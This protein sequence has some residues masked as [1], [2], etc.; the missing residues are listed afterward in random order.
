M[1]ATTTSA[2]AAVVPA[3]GKFAGTTSQ[4]YSGIVVRFRVSGSEVENKTI[5]WH[6]RCSSGSVLILSTLTRH[7]RIVHGRWS[8]PARYTAS[9][10][11][12][13]LAKIKV[14]K[15]T[16]QFTSP[17]SAT[18]VWSLRADLYRRGRKFDACATGTVRWAAGS[19]ASGRKSRLIVPPDRRVG[20]L[21]YAQWEVRAWQWETA[22]LHV[23]SSPVPNVTPC[24]TAGQRGPVWFL[25]ADAYAE[26]FATRS[27]TVP[28]GR[29]L[30]I[31]VPS[32]DCSTVERS[33][34]HATTDGGLLRCSK[35]KRLGRASLAV[36]G[37]V[38]SPA[39]ALVSTSAFP[40]TMLPVDNWLGVPGATAGRAAV[41]GL[42][43]MLRPLARGEHTIVRVDRGP[44]ATAT[45]ITYHVTVA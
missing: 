11:G 24:A 10:P 15:N 35:S 30:L 31:N 28:A 45:V 21:T 8:A 18:G 6:A 25:E 7:T 20:G 22:N 12:K 37:A 33:P 29:Y 23:Y 4:N 2:T 19:F 39:G 9:L 17:I 32:R 5:G 1:L 3:T 43:V 14:T 26:Y 42:V 41:H 36:D 16:G 13:I 34:F 27:C 40:F 44:D 38:L